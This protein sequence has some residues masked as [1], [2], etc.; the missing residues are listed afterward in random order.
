M[1]PSCS[2]PRR[3]A[4]GAS[5]TR[6]DQAGAPGAAP[7][8]AGARG[9]AA[10]QRAAPFRFEG[11]RCRLDWRLLHG[12]DIHKVV[13]P[14]RARLAASAAERRARSSLSRARGP[15]RGHA[16]VHRHPATLANANTHTHT[17]QACTHTTHPHAHSICTP[18]HH[19][20]IRDTDI[21]A[22]ERAAS[23][24]AWGDLEA[25]DPRQLSEANFVKAFRLA[26]LLV[27]YLLHVQA[28]ARCAS[29]AATHPVHSNACMLAPEAR[30][31]RGRG[32]RRPR[33]GASRGLL[34]LL[35]VVS[36]RSHARPQA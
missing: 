12:I 14:R 16:R 20:K 10:Q 34:A 19:P 1:D 18:H 32:R 29:R 6:R 27:E 15:A 4:A 7:G 31:A 35:H 33:L 2:R 30:P 13:G 23:V 9:A 11:K 28:R 8:G 5:V 21:D 24:I 36:T 3:D 17:P 25:E 26:Q 22:L